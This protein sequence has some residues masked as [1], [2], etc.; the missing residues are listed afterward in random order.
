MGVQRPGDS[1]SLGDIQEDFPEEGVSKGRAEGWLNVP[2]E[3]N[4][5]CKYSHICSGNRR[6]L[7]MLMF[8]TC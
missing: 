6:R 5:M 7:V 8:S 1:P 4:N 2:A 3:K